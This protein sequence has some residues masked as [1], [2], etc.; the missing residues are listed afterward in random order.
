[1]TAAECRAAQ[2]RVNKKAETQ[3]RGNDDA[4]AAQRRD[5]QQAD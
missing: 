5:A 2:Q 4:A 1:M 3:R